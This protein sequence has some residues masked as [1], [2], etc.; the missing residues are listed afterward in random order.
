MIP[1]TMVHM[2]IY[3]WKDMFGMIRYDICDG[4]MGWK[5]MVI[6]LVGGDW[7]PWI[8]IVPILIVGCDYHPNWR[9]HIFQRGGPTTNQILLIIINYSDNYG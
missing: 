3:G 7:L 4:M 1:V 5:D 8:L 6:D 9:T 2:M